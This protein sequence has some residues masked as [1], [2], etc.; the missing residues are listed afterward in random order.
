M[1]RSYGVRESNQQLIR[2]GGEI[3]RTP[4]WGPISDGRKYLIKCILMRVPIEN[5][6]GL[7]N[8]GIRF[9]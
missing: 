3:K 1:C 2:K 5:G 6:S 9:Y 4:V 8:Q 7:I